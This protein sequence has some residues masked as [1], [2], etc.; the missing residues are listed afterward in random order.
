M[1]KLLTISI[2]IIMAAMLLTGCAQVMLADCDCGGVLGGGTDGY[3][4]IEFFVQGYEPP[5]T[6]IAGNWLWQGENNSFEKIRFSSDGTF[7]L[8]S[9]LNDVLQIKEGAYTYDDSRL[10]L[11][12]NGDHYLLEYSRTGSNLSLKHKNGSLVFILSD[13]T[14]N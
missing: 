11:N 4:G 3:G 5:L 10:E 9:H 6:G 12:I 1:K 2:L 13:N 8:Q 7:I 14:P